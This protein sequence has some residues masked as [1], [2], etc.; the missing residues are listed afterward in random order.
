MKSAKVNDWVEGL[1][2][3]IPP[4]G[5]NLATSF[6]DDEVVLFDNASG[7]T[8]RLNQ[9]AL[10]VWQQCDGANSIGDIAKHLTQQ[11]EV[12]LET[13]LDHVEQ[14]VAMF[15]EADLF[16]RSGGIRPGGAVR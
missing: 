7:K 12:E 14:L 10:A 2:R 4:Q 3:W 15:A 8:H 5:K 13:A 11:F 6:L 9:A 16:E 1:D